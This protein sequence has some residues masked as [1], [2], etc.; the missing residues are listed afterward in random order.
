MN[1]EWPGNVRQLKNVI[2]RLVILADHNILDFLYLLDHLKVKQSWKE[3][4]IP[5]TFEELKALKKQLIEENFGPT[6][7]AFIIKAL[8]DSNG[9]ISHAAEKVGMQRPNFHRM[10]K[11]HHISVKTTPNQPETEIQK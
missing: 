3:N 4:S 6:E 1:Y 10:M 8:K 5:G 9:N 2:E 11:K 7:K